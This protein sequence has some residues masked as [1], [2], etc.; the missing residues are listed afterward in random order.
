ME[1]KTIEISKIT[2]DE[3]LE[4]TV[5]LDDLEAEIRKTEEFLKELKKLKNKLD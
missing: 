5:N 1:E 2:H 3:E 4:K